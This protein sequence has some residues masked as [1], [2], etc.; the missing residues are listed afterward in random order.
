MRKMLALLVLCLVGTA[1]SAPALDIQIGV[2]V[3]AR[4]VTVN[5][6]LYDVRFM[7]GSCVSLFSGC[8]SPSDFA[9]TTGTDALAASRALLDQ[10]FL[11]GFQGT[12]DSDPGLTR[13][14]ESAFQIGACSI[15]TPFDTLVNNALADN[16]AVE[17]FDGVRAAFTLPGED[18]TRYGTVVYAVWAPVMAVPEPSAGLMMVIGAMVLIGLGGIRRRGI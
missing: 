4:D 9:F 8:D 7:D 16:S 1:H 2:L 12:F 18:L 3:G 11:D 15:F 6:V 14:C 5:G 17:S 13:G 10:V